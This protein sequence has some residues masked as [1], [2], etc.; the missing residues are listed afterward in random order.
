MLR[1]VFR[2][3]FLNFVSICYIIIGTAFAPV[4][5]WIEHRPPTPG[6]RRFDSYQA[7]H[8][9]ASYISLAL[10]FLQKSEFAYIAA[11]PLL[12]KGTLGS[13]ARLQAPSLR[14]TVA[15]TF[16]RVRLRRRVS[17]LIVFPRKTA[18]FSK[19]VCFLLYLSHLFFLL[20]S[21]KESCYFQIK[22]KGAQK[23]SSLHLILQGADI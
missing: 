9:G 6:C 21:L 18:I 17:L 5:Q 15:T 7:R 2:L 12:P 19:K 13:P 4:A 14:L 1:Q 8:V 20:S 22:D 3:F 16:L 10:I 11:P 23:W